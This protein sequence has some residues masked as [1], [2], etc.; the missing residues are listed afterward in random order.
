M[1]REALRTSVKYGEITA[2]VIHR[3]VNVVP[4]LASTAGAARPIHQRL[5]PLPDENASFAMTSSL[6]SSVEAPRL[7]AASTILRE[8]TLPY[9]EKLSE[10][11]KNYERKIFTLRAHTVPQESDMM[12]VS[13]DKERGVG[14]E[15]NTELNFNLT[16]GWRGVESEIGKGNEAD[17]FEGG[18]TRERQQENYGQEKL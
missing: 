1:S 2:G 12:L 15:L 7:F 9:K 11:R 4:S 3:S 8:I 14:A 6:P 18:K 10:V 13:R 16:V 5:T 17:R